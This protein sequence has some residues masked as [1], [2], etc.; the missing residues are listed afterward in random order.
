MAWRK[1]CCAVD[2]S[3]ESRAALEEA[4]ELAWRFGGDLTVVHVDDRPIRPGA[5]ESLA[6]AEIVERGTVE[7]ERMTAAWRDQA[8]RIT[9]KPA[10][11][12]LLS[13]VPSEEITRFAR[14]RGF[15]V[16]VMGTHGQ[17]RGDREAIGSVAQAVVRE[18]PCTVAVVRGRAEHGDALP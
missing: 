10:D 13:G 11:Y 5:A 4:A 9:K 1:V 2:F 17:A 18:A 3:K 16:I 12:A 6:S 15:D 7:L 14:E 8:E